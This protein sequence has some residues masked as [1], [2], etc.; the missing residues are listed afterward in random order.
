MTYA[1]I[2]EALPDRA[3]E[4]FAGIGYPLSLRGLAAGEH[5]VDIGSGAGFDSFV[6]SGQVTSHG[7]VVGVAGCPVRAGNRCWWTAAS[8]TSRSVLRST[9]SVELEERPTFVR[10]F[11]VYGYAFLAGRR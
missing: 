6:A 2:L 5:V 11:E 10:S 4:S 8:V 9:R 1:A 3:V 7:R